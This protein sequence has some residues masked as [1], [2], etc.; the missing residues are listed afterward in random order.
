MKEFA[1]TFFIC[2]VTSYVILFFCADFILGNLFGMLTVFSLIAAAVITAFAELYGKIDKLEKRLT[3]LE[4]T[5][6]KK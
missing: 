3:G 6:D 1:V 2:L 4:N 5:D